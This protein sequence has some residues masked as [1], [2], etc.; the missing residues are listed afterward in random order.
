MFGKSVEYSLFEALT[1]YLPFPANI[2]TA[3]LWLFSPIVSRLASLDNKMN[4]LVRTT[5]AITIVE[6]GYKSNVIP[7]TARAVIDHRIHPGSSI[8]STLDH[9]RKVI[10]DDRIK[11]NVLSDAKEPDPMTPI[12]SEIGIKIR[13]SIHRTL[14]NTNVIPGIFVALAD[15]RWLTEFSEHIFRFAPMKME[16][17]EVS[18]IHGPDERISV[19]AF[20]EAI[21]FCYDF[22]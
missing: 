12:D 6:A 9:L 21:N 4:S 5:T 7:T 16:S 10:N 13:N 22:Y 18:G 20:E 2:L 17:N 14:S 11:I 1:P 3:N 8:A 19:A 15:S